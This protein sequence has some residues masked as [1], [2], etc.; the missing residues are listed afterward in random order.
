MPVVNLG[1]VGALAI[2]A[3]DLSLVQDIIGAMRTADAGAA[4]ASGSPLTPLPSIEPWQHIQPDPVY[5]RPRVIHADPIYA[6]RKVI[7]P[8][9]R[10]EPRLALQPLPPAP[11][12]TEPDPGQFVIKPPWAILPWQEPANPPAQ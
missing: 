9:P 1:D 8:E 10:F 12:K 7:H 6:R 4:A 11:Q 2:A 3:L 5:E